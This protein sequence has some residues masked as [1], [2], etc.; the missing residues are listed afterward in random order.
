MGGSF[1]SKVRD[2]PEYKVR[3]GIEIGKKKK[4]YGREM[5][6]RDVQLDRNRVVVV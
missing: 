1:R 6:T 4:M 5:C 3:C 2:Y